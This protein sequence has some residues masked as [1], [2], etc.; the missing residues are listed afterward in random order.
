MSASDLR[1][2]ERLKA[3]Y[4]EG[5][6]TAKLGVLRRL[7]RSRL[8]TAGQVER[9]HEAL[10][11]LRAY[12]DDARVLAQVTRLMRP[13]NFLGLPS[14]AVPCGF[15]PH[16]L[17]CA[18]QLIGRPFDEALLF[19]LGHAYQGATDWHLRVPDGLDA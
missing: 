19:R 2:L 17:P 1:R 9:L 12:P 6:A 16:G 8:R 10:C 4:G 15:Q 13:V 3:T 18:F 11:F 7:S 5:V 14:L